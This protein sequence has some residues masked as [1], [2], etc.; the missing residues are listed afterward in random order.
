MV[1]APIGVW[2]T[3]WLLRARCTAMV[4]SLL[5][6]IRALDRSEL[7]TDFTSFKC[8]GICVGQVHTESVLPV[9]LVSGALEL[10]GGV[11][12]PCA[13][14][15]SVGAAAVARRTKQLIV[16]ATA[17]ADAGI[18]KKLH[19]EEFAVAAG[20]GEPELARV[21]RAAAKFFGATSVG[22]H[23]MCHG[24]SDGDAAPDWEDRDDSFVWMA[25]RADDKSEAPGLWDP[26]AAG[27]LPAGTSVAEHA[28]AE[29]YEEAGVDAALFS[30]AA[31]ATSALSLMTADDTS[32]ALKQS[33]Y[34]CFDARVSRA[35]APRAVDGEVG[36]FARWSFEEIEREV[37][38]GERLRPAM[39]AV[40]LDFLVRHGHVTADNE[41]AY[42]ELQS[43]MHMPRLRLS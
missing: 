37:R 43:A 20:W 7:A 31:R 29:A 9:L 40:M 27:G 35:W 16:A 18:V 1:R 38:E 15:E 32:R 36:A 5:S 21:N 8:A 30:H 14:D 23:V 34:F 17:L 19:A 33:L 2:L 39:R 10:A 41:P 42:I 12:R 26:T 6:R 3:V 22:V 28:A 25:R 13:D 11:L 24:G 4:P